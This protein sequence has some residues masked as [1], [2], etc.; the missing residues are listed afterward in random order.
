MKRKY[1]GTLMVFSLSSI[2]STPTPS[3]DFPEFNEK[4]T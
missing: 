4:N 2:Q 1:L 3:I